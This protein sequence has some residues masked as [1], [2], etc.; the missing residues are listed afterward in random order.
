[1]AS[2]KDQLLGRKMGFTGYGLFMGYGGFINFEIG[3]QI[4]INN[5]QNIGIDLKLIR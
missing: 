5:S 4:L 1:M 3:P 2:R